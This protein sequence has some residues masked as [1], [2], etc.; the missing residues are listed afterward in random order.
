MQFPPDVVSSA[1]IVRWN[2]ADEA[3]R[4]TVA[5]MDLFKWET[6]STV[7]MPM[8]PFSIIRSN[9]SSGMSSKPELNDDD[10]DIHSLSMDILHRIILLWSRSIFFSRLSPEPKKRR[11]L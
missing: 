9:T 6:E 11:R 3:K 8:R 4:L 10:I 2:W 7:D 5:R 1:S